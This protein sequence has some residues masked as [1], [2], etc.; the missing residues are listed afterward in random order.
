[1]SRLRQ[2]SDRNH[3]GFSDWATVFWHDGCTDEQQLIRQQINE[4]RKDFAIENDLALITRPGRSAADGER[5][6]ARRAQH[7]QPSRPDD[8]LTRDK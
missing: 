5:T 1:M 2:V 8:N 7:R 6:R 4:A 3:L